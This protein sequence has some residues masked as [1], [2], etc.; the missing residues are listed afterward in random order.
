MKYVV[1]IK[2]DLILNV[3]SLGLDCWSGK[4]SNVMT[5]ARTLGNSVSVVT[6]LFQTPNL[7][8]VPMWNVFVFVGCVSRCIQK[9]PKQFEAKITPPFASE[10]F[11]PIFNQLP[12]MTWHNQKFP[13]NSDRQV[14]IEYFTQHRVVWVQFH[15]FLMVAFHLTSQDSQTTS[16]LAARTGAY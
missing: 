1:G 8:C 16:P 3:I 7:L 5:L 9:E 4:T 6:A 15:R 11:I 12:R 14:L 2:F 10:C 13:F